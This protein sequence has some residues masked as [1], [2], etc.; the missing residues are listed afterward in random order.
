MAARCGVGHSWLVFSD[1][2]GVRARIELRASC[3]LPAA[4]SARQQGSPLEVCRNSWWPF[5]LLLLQVSVA[6]LQRIP[7]NVPLTCFEIWRADGLS[8]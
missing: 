3:V 2:A 1:I 6:P 5:Q 4:Y 8:S 7:A